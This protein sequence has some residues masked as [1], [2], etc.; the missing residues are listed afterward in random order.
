M[1]LSVTQL[2]DAVTERVQLLATRLRVLEDKDAIRELVARYGP[3]ADAGDAAGVAGLWSESGT[4]AV[5]GVAEAKGQAAI[6]GLIDGEMH[7]NLLAKGCAHL[8]GHVAIE[9]D[10]DTAVARGHSVVFCRD[11][12]G[13][14]VWRVAANRWELTRMPEGWRVS[15]RINAPLDGGE[16]ARMLLGF[17]DLA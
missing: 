8:L 11:E 2:T 6:A 17:A 9:L 15:R 4:Y 7:Q 12:T 5:G 14:I 3:M 16:A 13:Y 1:R 10:G